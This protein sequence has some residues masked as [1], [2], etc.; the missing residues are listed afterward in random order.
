MTHEV[1]A[2]RARL[3]LAQ[4]LRR[5]MYVRNPAILDSVTQDMNEWIYESVWNYNHHHNF[6]FMLVNEYADNQGYSYLDE[7]KYSKCSPFLKAFFS[8]AGKPAA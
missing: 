8:G 7:E 6:Y 2:V 3:N 4:H 1:H 5:Y